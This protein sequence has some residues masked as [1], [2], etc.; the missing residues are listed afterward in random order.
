MRDEAD[1]ER[2]YLVWVRIDGVVRRILI[3]ARTAEAARTRPAQDLHRGQQQTY[4]T[5]EGG[6]PGEL[7]VVWL[8][9][10]TLEVGEPHPTRTPRPRG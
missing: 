6:S 1:E 4:P 2:E 5:V 10:A 9:V 3:K 8:N 7:T